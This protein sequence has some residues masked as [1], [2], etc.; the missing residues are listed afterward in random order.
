MPTH[1]ET[2]KVNLLSLNPT[3]LEAFFVSLGEK[4]YRAHQV[5]KW[6]DVQGIRDIESMTNL[7]KALRVKLAEVA[8]ICP[9]K[10]NTTEP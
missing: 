1:P 2:A 7:S 8:E 5:L 4:P 9:V 3:A 10:R 6:L